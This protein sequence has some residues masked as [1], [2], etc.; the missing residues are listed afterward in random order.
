M[1]YYRKLPSGRW[2][3]EVEVSGQRENQGGFPTK[4][5]AQEWASRTEADM[6]A[7]KLGK[8]P[9]KTLGDAI[10]RYIREVTVSKGS[11]AN[12]EARLEAFKREFK[13][14]AAKRF[15]D[16]TP[17]DLTKW[18]AKRLET[19]KPSTV[20]RESNT[21][22]NIWTVGAK[23]WRWCSLESP[24]TFVSVPTDGPARDRRVAWQEVRAI[25]RALGYL[26]RRPPVTKQQETAYAWLVALRS[27]MRAGE[28]RSLTTDAVDL[29]TRVVTLGKHKTFRYTGRPR[30]VPITKHSARLLAV[31]V[32]GA[33]AAG[34]LE[35]FTVSSE[36]MGSLF[37]K[38]ARR[39]GITDMRF[40]DSRGEALTRL[41]QKH[42]LKTLQKISGHVDI[43]VLADH[44]YRESPE[45]I[46]KRL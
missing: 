1:A 31:L 36:S 26:P 35:L 39:V 28:I 7:G 42:D 8:W 23:V 44:Y 6:R 20:S 34:R 41:S 22:S 18:V 14:L 43:R 13:D 11:K 45:D 33:E 16:I 3:A 40:H 5:E 37:Y 9:L 24:W 27:A 25:C 46:A 38:A 17:D 10:D 29:E 15:T 12:E 2:R 30:F 4:R 21:L 19:V 32:A